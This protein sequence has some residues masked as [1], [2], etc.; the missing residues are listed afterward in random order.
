MRSPPISQARA[1]TSAALT[2]PAHGRCAHRVAQQ[3][4][5]QRRASKEALGAEGT[6]GAAGQDGVGLAAADSAQA[7]AD[8]V[9]PGVEL[10][11]AAARRT[12]GAAASDEVPPWVAP[13]GGPSGGSE[14]SRS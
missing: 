6:R 9:E 14:D 7:A 3:K 2:G 11:T 12:G 1:A 4:A 10:G 13:S 8:D 5:R